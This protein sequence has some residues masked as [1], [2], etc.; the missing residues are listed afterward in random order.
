MRIANVI[1]GWVP[2]W[3]VGIGIMVV[4]AIVVMVVYRWFIWR[5]IRLAERHSPFLQQLL[6]RG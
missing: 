1:S 2:H 4:P 6:Q 3:V 5:V